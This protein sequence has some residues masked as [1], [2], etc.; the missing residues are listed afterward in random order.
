DMKPASATVRIG[1]SIDITPWARVKERECLGTVCYGELC[2]PNCDTV[3]N[4][5][6]FTN[7]KPGDSRTW[8]VNDVENGN[9]TVG[10][11]AAKATAGA[12]FTAPAQKPSPDTVEVKFVSLNGSTGDF[13]FPHAKVKITADYDMTATFYAI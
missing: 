1:N 12:T 7:S 8:Y 3:V 4:D 2:F 13:V 6:P 9:S 5:Y 10:T 11:I